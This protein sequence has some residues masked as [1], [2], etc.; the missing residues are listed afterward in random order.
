MKGLQR[1]IA[2]AGETVLPIV[3]RTIALNSLPCAVDGASGI[4][5]GGGKIPVVLPE[6]RLLIHGAVLRARG[7]KTTAGITTTWT[8]AFAVATA[9]ASTTDI[10]DDIIEEVAVGAADTSL[11]PIVEKSNAVAQ[12]VNNTQGDVELFLNVA[13]A[14]AAINA[15]DQNVNVSGTLILLYSVM[16]DLPN[17]G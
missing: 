8:G 7:L 14:D 11:S 17:V 5:F 12:F 6:G 3:R 1:S 15:D 13:V 10:E 9:I 16:G 4:G 2:R